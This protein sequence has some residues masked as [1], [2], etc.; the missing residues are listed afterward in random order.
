MTIWLGRVS[1]VFDTAKRI[2]MVRLTDGSISDQSE[3]DLPDGSV[4][5]RIGRLQ[6]L[7]INTLVCG[8]ISRPLAC[9]VEEAGIHL[10]PFVAGPVEDILEALAIGELDDRY[11]MPGCCSQRKRH[12]RGRRGC[13]W[14]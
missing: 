14:Q 11:R 6:S 5:D 2:L 3:E 12:R 4:A 8:A 7:K 9:M 1:P 10:V 13:K